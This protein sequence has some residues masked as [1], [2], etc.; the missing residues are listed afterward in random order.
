MNLPSPIQTFFDADQRH[1]GEALINVFTS[2]ALVKDEG[3]SYPGRQAIDAWWRASK[4]KYQ[5]VTEPLEAAEKGDV[6][7][8]RARVSGQFPSSP[9]TL[10]FAFRIKGDQ[11]TSLDISA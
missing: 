2:D 7:K 4:I 8:V 11:I 5:H 10:I 1:D 3:R 6:M 9:A